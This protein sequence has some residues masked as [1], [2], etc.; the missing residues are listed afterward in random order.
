MSGGALA[1]DIHGRRHHVGDR[2]GEE[3]G[4]FCGDAGIFSAR[5][6][7]GVYGGDCRAFVHV[8]GINVGVRCLQLQGD[9]SGSAA[10]RAAEGD[11]DR[12]PSGTLHERHALRLGSAGK[13]AVTGDQDAFCTAPAS[14]ELGGRLFAYTGMF[15]PLLT[16]LRSPVP[17]LRA[18]AG[19]NVMLRRDFLAA[20]DVTWSGE[21]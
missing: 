21:M 2:G 14:R 18:H 5:D 3:P 10:E 9:H 20:D 4:E 15:A 13:V 7:G 16:Q 19:L 6:V 8:V 1:G 17:G 11:F 12:F